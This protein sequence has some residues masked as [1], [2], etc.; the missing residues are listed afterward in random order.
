MTTSATAPP[1]CVASGNV[2]ADLAAQDRAVEFRKFLNLINRNVPDDPDV[3]VIVDNSSTHKTPAIHRW[4][5][6]HPHFEL[7]FTPCPRHPG[8]VLGRVG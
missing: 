6:R 3:H 4:L 2:I 8:E 1:T 5:V 7:H